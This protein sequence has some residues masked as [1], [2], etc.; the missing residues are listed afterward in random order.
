MRATLVRVGVDQTFGGWNAP[1]DPASGAF[2]YVP[3]PDDGPFHPGMRRAY[4]ELRAPL[5]AFAAA[6][7]RPGAPALALPPALARRAMHLDPDFDHLTYGDNGLRRGRGVS[8]LARGD[9]IAFFA[10]LRSLAD[11]APRRLVYALIGVYR[12]DEVVRLPDIE[13]ARRHENAHTRRRHPH[14][15][16]VIVRAARAGSGRLRRALPIGGWRD[17]AYRVT[18]ALLAA[19][20]GLSC[21]DGFL[22]RSGVPP[23]LVDPRRFLRWLDARRPELVAANHPPLTR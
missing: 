12:V 3:I 20:G 6:H 2:V 13:P 18:P 11:A 5:A 15:G 23:M 1:F 10:G 17:G 22:Q 9:V 7:G 16:D 21:R 14:A 8:E 19:W 4:R